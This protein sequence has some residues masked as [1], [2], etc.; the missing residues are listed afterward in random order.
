VTI[1][2]R[3]LRRDLG[4]RRGQ[5]VAVAVTVFLGISLFGASYDAFENLKA[6][7]ATLYDRLAFADLTV[8]G[9][10]AEAFAATVAADPDVAAT[11]TRRTAE[12]PLRLTETDKL[13]SRLV[14]LPATGD[15]AVDKVL[16]KDGHGLDPSEP[17]GILVEQHLAGDHDLAP[18]D[19]VDV[20]LADGWRTLT[21]DGIVASPEYL[22]PARSRQEILTSTR[23][24]GVIF[25]GP[26]VLDAAGPVAATQALVRYRP[27][28]D[29]ATVDGRLTAAARAAG[30][31][32]IET[33][34]DQPSNAALQEDVSGFG[35]LSLMFPV[36]FLAVAALATYVL[37]TRLV[38]SERPQI[39]LLM[40]EGFQRRT[41]F[42]HYLGYGLVV[43]LAGAIP[44]V[45]AGALL[46]S[47]ITSLYTG[48]LAIPI[49]V[50]EVRPVTIVAGLAVGIV[51][52]LLA[53]LGPAWS[54]SHATPAEAM[55]GAS[56]TTSGG[57]RSLAERLV[58]PLARLPGRWKLVLR[59]IG[60]NRRRSLSTIIGIVLASVLILVSWG[61]IDT[62]QI[63]L[64]RQFGEV[65]REDATVYLAGPADEGALA[66]VAAIPGVARVEPV[67][68][69]E[70]VVATDHDQ[71]ST[72]LIG[73]EPRTRMHG[74]RLDGGSPPAG[75]DQL[76]L[77]SALRDRLGVAVGGQVRVRLA[78]AAEATPMTVAGFVGEP[79]GTYAYTTAAGA[80]RLLEG[81]GV[82]S[83]TLPGIAMVQYEPG[84]DRAAMRS[85]L[86]GLP[87]VA[88]FVD[89][90]ALYD[91]AQQYLG[92]FYVFLGVMLA[93]GA[94]MALALILT[95]V[96]ANVAE[97]SSELASL[98]ANGM[99]AGGIARLVAG[100]NLLLVVIG[101]VPGL[102]I[103]YATAWIFMA[104]FSSDLFSFDLAV[105]PTTIVL[106]GLA[107]VVVAIASL[108][109]AGR[110][111]R[112]LDVARVVRERSM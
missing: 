110:T 12:V 6:S 81:A 23:D 53:A 73:F 28:A 36:L 82:D 101:V 99:S 59:G 58:P 112:H 84:R 67:T 44:G 89:S 2:Q 103:G 50:V 45:I 61:M 68:E 96:A 47:A 34:A 30:A 18:G 77:G 106:S 60:R 38:L 76:V 27:G 91:L 8:T 22:W 26:A 15:P 71:Y 100:E 72:V 79:L 40:A 52:G 56:F 20:L 5:V 17:D 88:A 57:G 85:T 90:R 74:Y 92:L 69:L 86:G 3:K 66:A 83:A 107:I 33:Q 51:A 104:T 11:T 7:Y 48:A 39:G 1:L 111:I 46:A 16:L 4:R 29:V 102:A 24:F 87:G 75:E 35:E 25:A 37:L 13:V 80:G 62:V 98:R 9:A 21:V 49:Q 63:L 108:V 10:S 19:R 54:A 109:P 105:H 64:E 55:R 65:Q 41:I 70:V 14:E 93:F 94:I 32:A 97:R 42:R 43:A 31:D 78:G 95:T